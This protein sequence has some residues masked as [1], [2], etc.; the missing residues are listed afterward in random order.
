MAGV[1]FVLMLTRLVGTRK[2]AER[3]LAGRD[4][5]VRKVY[6]VIPFGKGLYGPRFEVPFMGVGGFLFTAEIE[7]DDHRRRTICHVRAGWDG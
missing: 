4:Y 3:L 1:P 7:I 6:R 2:D 5:E